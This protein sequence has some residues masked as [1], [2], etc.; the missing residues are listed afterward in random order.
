[1]DFLFCFRVVAAGGRVIEG[2]VWEEKNG[3]AP[4][5]SSL[6]ILFVYLNP[7]VGNDLKQAFFL[8]PHACTVNVFVGI[9]SLQNLKSSESS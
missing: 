7:D 9:K 2:G 1:M 4:G 8:P 6:G 5:C 3:A